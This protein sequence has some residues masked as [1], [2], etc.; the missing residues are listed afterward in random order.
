MIELKN[1]AD[2]RPLAEEN[3]AEIMETVV[4]PAL[5]EIR[6]EGYMTFEGGRKIHYAYYVRPDAKGSIVISH[7]FTETAEKFREM[8][9]YFLEGGYNVFAM[10]HR[11]HGYSSREVED[12]RIAHVEH[13]SDYVGDF[14]AF[15]ENV[16]RPH[17]GDLP[18]ILF[19]HSM[20]GA[21]AALYIQQF[22]DVFDKAILS[23][24]MI[25]PKT[26]GFP[27]WV[28]KVMAGTF[29]LAGKRKALV[30]T[31]KGFDPDFTYE[32]SNDTSKARF[33]YYYDK[34][35][36]TPEYQTCGASYG[37]VME[38]LKI[39][40]QMLDPINCGNVQTKVLLFQPAVDDVV[41]MEPQAEFVSKIAGARLV[42]IPASKHEIYLSVNEGMEPYL[43]EIFS[44]L[45]EE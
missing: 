16:V 27:H 4:E 18:L 30:F 6:R 1:A 25:S 31:E 36:K 38:S 24:P 23:S 43:R 14:N 9:Y 13:F 17:S 42:K 44:F 26:A 40:P 5:K 32:R 19:S 33:D 22:P 39:I 15:V 11:G 35:R 37:W 12:M 3:Y 28:T 20:G 45:A 21:V 7:G 10:D 2:I 34:R 8:A 29:I 41:E